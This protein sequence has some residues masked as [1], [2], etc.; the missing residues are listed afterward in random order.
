MYL[1]TCHKIYPPVNKLNFS[2]AQAPLPKKNN[3]ERVSS[4]PD[5]REK[6]NINFVFR[7]GGR[8]EASLSDV[9]N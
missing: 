9:K 8:G 2:F 1:A 6:K 7:G 3:V 4:R 5:K